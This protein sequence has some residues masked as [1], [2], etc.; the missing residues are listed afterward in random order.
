[1]VNIEPA[2]SLKKS[3]NPADIQTNLVK[4]KTVSRSLD[5]NKIN[6]S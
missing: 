1:M 6:Y 2:Q 3:L 4:D 5:V